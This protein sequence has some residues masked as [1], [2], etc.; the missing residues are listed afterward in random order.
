MDANTG[1]DWLDIQS[2]GPSLEP[3]TLFLGHSNS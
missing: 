1:V 2:T 3:W